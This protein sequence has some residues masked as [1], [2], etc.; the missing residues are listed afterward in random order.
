MN[1]NT[2]K[3]LAYT[4]AINSIS[5]PYFMGERRS[6]GIRKRSIELAPIPKTVLHEFSIHGVKI[7][8][9]SRKD[10]IKKYNNKH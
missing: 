3:F 8:A 1:Y 7:M 4:M 10:A 9:K 6:T 2:L 5:N